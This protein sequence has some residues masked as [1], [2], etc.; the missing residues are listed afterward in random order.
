MAAILATLVALF[1][2]VGEAAASRI[3]PVEV[4]TLGVATA[5]DRNGDGGVAEGGV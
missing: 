5:L 4:S 1:T 3:L 2:G